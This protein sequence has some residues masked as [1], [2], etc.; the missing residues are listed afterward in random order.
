M[1][2]KVVYTLYTIFTFTLLFCC[3]LFIY[4][5]QNTLPS[6]VT[7]SG[8]PVEGMSV[9]QVE[10]QMNSIMTMLGN[11]QLYL[12]CNGI[13]CADA[14]EENRLKRP[15]LWDSR[16]I[17]LRELGI[18]NNIGELLKLFRAVESGPWFKKAWHRWQLRE[19]HLSLTAAFDTSIL[20][21]TLQQV[22]R[23]ANQFKPVNA[24]RI[25]MPDDKITINPETNAYRIDLLKL[26]QRLEESLGR[27]SWLQKLQKGQPLSL[28]VNLPLL[29]EKP[30]VTKQSLADQGISRKISEF[31]TAL[32]TSAAGRIHNITATAETIQNQL[33]APGDIFD[34]S[35]IIQQT[36]KNSRY[37]EAPVILNGKLVPGIGGGICQVSST[38][39]NA[40]LRAGLQIIERRNHSLPVSYV[41][42]GQDATYAEGYINFRFRNSSDHFLLIRT[43]VEHNEF[44][45]KLF[46]TVSEQTTYDISTNIVS[47]L[48][49]PTRYLLNTELAVNAHE[50]IQEGKQG[51]IVET[52][53]LQKSNNVVI[54]KELISRDTYPA[55]PTLVAVGKGLIGKE[56]S[57]KAPPINP[58]KNAPLL[59]DGVSGPNFK[60]GQ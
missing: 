21:N 44:T 52:F 25:I 8:W 6:G 29:I 47:Y 11:E 34:Y 7:L 26:Q 56:P 45:L 13:G 3:V 22:W 16:K 53:R 27:S 46:G 49:P 35:K 4:G 24:E 5:S 23:T 36:E 19:A 2:H 18:Q 39:Y 9:P 1:R 43:S 14:S 37:Q 40:V 28:T 60:G 51:F 54:R 30:I 10:L 33:L 59:E 15:F 41:P 57:G 17:A 42:L 38:L 20:S 32:G 58:N 50:V 55:Q 12:N 31:T 48:P